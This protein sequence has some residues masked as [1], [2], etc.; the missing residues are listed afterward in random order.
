MRR[1]LVRG[2]G[3][4]HVIGLR[5]WRSAAAIAAIAV[6]I[7]GCAGPLPGPVAAT[8][9]TPAAQRLV[10]Q[11]DGRTILEIPGPPVP[12]LTT[13]LVRQIELPGVI[14]ANGQVAFDDRRVAT[15]VSRVAGRIDATRVSQWDNVRRGQP[16]VALYSPDFMTAE[17]EFLQAKITAR[18]S[19]APA[20][21]QAASADFG[22]PV[23]VEGN[24]AGA[25]VMAEIGRASCRERV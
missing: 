9:P 6:A 22:A 2:R 4:E 12:G 21:T 3:S 16:I 15:I 20:A 14:E 17:A 8:T 23:A 10:T 13:A 5:G 18:L 24:L 19:V 7:G 25:M 1:R 11:A